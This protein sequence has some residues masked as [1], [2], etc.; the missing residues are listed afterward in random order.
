MREGNVSLED[1]SN[2]IDEHR[3]KLYNEHIR[4][5]Q[6]LIEK[7]EKELS[8]KIQDGRIGEAYGD[9]EE[10]I[11][12]L[13]KLNLSRKIQDYNTW[14]VIE[15]RY[16]EL[17]EIRR[18]TTWRKLAKIEV[19][20]KKVLDAIELHLKVLGDEVAHKTKLETRTALA[21]FLESKR[22]EIETLLNEIDLMMKK[23]M[24]TI[25]GAHIILPQDVSVDLVLPDFKPRAM[26]LD[27]IKEEW[28]KLVSE[29]VSEKVKESFRP[30][31]ALFRFD[32]VSEGWYVPQ[33]E[34]ATTKERL[35]IAVIPSFVQIRERDHVDRIVEKK[36]FNATVYRFIFGVA[37][38]EIEVR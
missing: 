15:K 29:K 24:D 3:E 14:E 26:R 32:G 23:E 33:G 11:N 36:G 4:R 21:R 9:I 5:R 31:L 18:K 12:Y 6:S 10:T 30:V 27:E 7:L 20:A 22:R 19:A 25:S 28:F 34:V 17:E 37:L 8:E 16:A 35:T 1:I 13:N 2:I 38:H